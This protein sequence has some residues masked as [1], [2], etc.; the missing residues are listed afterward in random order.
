MTRK[1][2][3]SRERIV[4]AAHPRAL[5][6]FLASRPMP[7]MHHGHG[8]VE[9]VREADHKG[10]H[11]VIRTTYV[12]EVDGRTLDLPLGVDN[13]GHVHCHSLP[14]Y[15]FSSAIG[16]VKQIIDTF[17][18]DFPKPGKPPKTPPTPSPHDGMHMS[19]PMPSE[20]PKRKKK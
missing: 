6:G 19:M 1:Q 11:I 15:Q 2:L 10:H 18:G 9:G 20:S 14:N 12:V 7:M 13:D 16:L 5:S 3:I 4:E 17:P 8:K